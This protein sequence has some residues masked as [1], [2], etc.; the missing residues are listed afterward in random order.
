MQRLHLSKTTFA[1]RAAFCYRW[2]MAKFSTLRVAVCQM[3][4]GDNL[5]DN[6][7]QAETL[8]ARA[9]RKAAQLVALPENALYIGPDRAFALSLQSAPVMTLRTLARTYKI[10]LLVGSIPEACAHGKR[11]N[12]CLLIDPHGDIHARYRKIHRFRCTTPTGT[13]LSETDMRAGTRAVVAPTPW[14]KIGL[15]ICYDL[16]MPELFGALAKRGARIISVPA[17]FTS[18][19]G[20]AHWHVLLRARAIEN[21]AFV[22]APAQVGKK[23][24][25]TAFG[26]A[27]VI[28]PW[29]KILA[30]TKTARPDVLVTTLD[31]T[32]ID[33]VRAKLPALHD[34]FAHLTQWR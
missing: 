23:Y 33:R 29:G 1:V 26:H 21:Q 13:A 16:R 31:L 11:A 20:E 10:W 3:T 12:T 17:N 2:C 34:R 30:E 19:T 18:F 32:Q 9:A 5:A 24:H 14:G 6:L 28:D 25:M 22:I 15:T 27:L 4:S 8:V 7:R